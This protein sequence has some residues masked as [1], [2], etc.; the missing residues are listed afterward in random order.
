MNRKA[1]H[2]SA[3]SSNV[4][5]IVMFWRKSYWDLNFQWYKSVKMNKIR[6]FE[7]V[8]SFIV[9]QTM[10]IFNNTTV[11]NSLCQLL[12]QL[13]SFLTSSFQYLSWGARWASQQPCCV[14]FCW[15]LS[16]DQGSKISYHIPSKVWI[17]IT[18]PFPNFNG[19]TV[20]VWEWIY[21]FIPQFIMDVITYPCW[22]KVNPVY[23]YHWATCRQINPDK[24]PCTTVLVYAYI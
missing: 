23:I 21:N 8:I 18:Y 9:C 5:W 24:S 2:A 14:S 19:A 16:A 17:E 4:F 6:T 20:E 10:V 3:K 11:E 13:N 12:R 7:L 22:I 1:S 15:V